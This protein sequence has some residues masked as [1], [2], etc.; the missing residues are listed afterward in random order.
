MFLLCG[1]DKG[2]N[3]RMFCGPLKRGK[4]KVQLFIM[5]CG[6]LSEALEV[7]MMKCQTQGEL[8]K[9]VFVLYLIKITNYLCFFGPSYVERST[10]VC[11]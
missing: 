5:V 7:I 2:E 8:G 4:S 11:I 6:M 3:D 10:C 9:Y 1:R